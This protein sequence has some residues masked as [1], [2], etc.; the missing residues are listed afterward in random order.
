MPEKYHIPVL[1]KEVISTLLI[2]PHGTYM[3]GTLGG[4]GHAQLFLKQL[5]RKAKYIGI[6][7]D[8]EAIEYAK[9]KLKDFKN[10]IFY[11]NTFDDLEGA[12]KQSGS[13]KIDALLLDLG[14]S[15]RQIDEDLRGF[16]Y[17]PG[18]KLDMRMNRNEE[19]T[20]ADI[21]NEYVEKDIVSIFKNYGEERF[22][23]NIAR[24]VVKERASRSITDSEQLME[25]IKKSV[26]G[27]FFNKKLCSNF[28]GIADRI[29]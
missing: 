4:G 9:G 16:A 8:Q 5:S 11:Q 23:K 24:R 12:L 18:L 22:S 29:K 1:G 25:I 26:P 7:R 21:L 20:A 10:V 14:I 27:K 6:D 13:N 15:G 3:D 2:N 28:S 19:R 17:R